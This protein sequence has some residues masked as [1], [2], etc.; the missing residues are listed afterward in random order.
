LQP[1]FLEERNAIARQT[2][3]TQ[4]TP[5]QK[6]PSP[7]GLWAYYHAGRDD[8]NS[9]NVPFKSNSEDGSVRRGAKMDRVAEEILLKTPEAD[10][11]FAPSNV[12]SIISS[13]DRQEIKLSDVIK[14]IAEGKI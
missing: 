8:P 9:S 7:D 5:T 3:Q 11:L 12:E 13:N 14:M 2:S 4:S 1:L 10:E 6:R